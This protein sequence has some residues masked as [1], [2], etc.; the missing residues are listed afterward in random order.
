MFGGHFGLG[1]M[2]GNVERILAIMKYLN[3]YSIMISAEGMWTVDDLLDEDS[4]SDR[5]SLDKL[6]HLGTIHARRSFKL[7]D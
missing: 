1:V 4:Q 2:N 7:F 5:V 6:Q 3:K